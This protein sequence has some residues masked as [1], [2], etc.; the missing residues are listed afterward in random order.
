MFQN[1]DT[2]Q[3]IISVNQALANLT[4]RYTARKYVS[5]YPNPFNTMATIS[6]GM[7]EKGKVN[8]R[9]F[10]ISGRLVRSL[11]SGKQPAGS[12]FITWNGKNQQ[13]KTAA[14]GVYYVRIELPYK[15]YNKKLLAIK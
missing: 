9:V 5:V 3:K 1:G 7:S 11:Y 8:V 2:P 13:G 4:E 10:D 12:H 6:Y 15:T 14:I